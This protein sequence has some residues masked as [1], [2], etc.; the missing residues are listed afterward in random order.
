LQEQFK[1]FYLYKSHDLDKSFSKFR[2]NS[3]K[4]KRR[5]FS[6]ST[7]RDKKLSVNKRPQIANI[8]NRRFNPYQDAVDK[9]YDPHIRSGSIVPASVEKS[10]DRHFQAKADNGLPNSIHRS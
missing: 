4:L 7:N 9:G 1:E 8:Q 5:S 6:Q 3:T 2:K 10:M